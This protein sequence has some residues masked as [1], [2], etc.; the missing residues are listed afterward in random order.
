MTP[1]VITRSQTVTANNTTTNETIWMA[2]GTGMVKHTA[3]QANTAGSGTVT[4]VLR[5]FAR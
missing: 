3:V 4:T 5:S 1:L 2:R